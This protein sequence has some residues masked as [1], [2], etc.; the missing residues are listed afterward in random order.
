MGR[1]S[2]SWLSG[3]DAW[4][5]SCLKI[6]WDHKAWCAEVEC[7]VVAIVCWQ[8]TDTPGLLRRSDGNICLCR[9]S[10]IHY[11]CY[12]LLLTF[13]ILIAWF[14]VSHVEGHGSW[15]FKSQVCSILVL[16]SISIWYDCCRKSSFKKC[17]W[18]GCL[19]DERNNI[20]KLT[21][22]A[23][24]HLPTAILYVHDLTGDCGTTV[25]DQVN[26]HLA[27][28]SKLMP[29]FVHALELAWDL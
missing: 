28:K 25:P 29:F 23:L 13:C 21:L 27:C 26:P 9:S 6:V 10:T 14:K 18:I 19:T 4:N 17:L 16:V 2:L 7:V 24:S 8:V 11:F 20:E 22:A 5:T 3:S 15:Y 12:T 1:L